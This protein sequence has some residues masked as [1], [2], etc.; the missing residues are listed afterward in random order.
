MICIMWMQ[1]K[2]VRI[3]MRDLEGAK[4]SNY[5]EGSLDN[6]N[7]AEARVKSL[8]NSKAAC[9]AEITRGM[10][11]IRGKLVTYWVWLLR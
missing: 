4:T 1:Y 2:K 9:E 3:N 5:I 10:I 11:K 8:Q 6:K 7:E